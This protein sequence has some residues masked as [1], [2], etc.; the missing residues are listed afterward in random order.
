MSE[1]LERKKPGFDKEALRRKYREERDKR[2]RADGMDQYVEIDDQLSQNLE[3]PYIPRQERPSISDHVTFAFIGGGFS[4]LVTGARLVENGVMNVR[5]I[6]KGGDFGGTWYWNRYPGAICD[7]AA[8]VYLPLLE[9]TGHMPTKKYVFAPEILQQCKRIGTQYNLYDHALFHTQVT[10]L[11]WDENNSRWQITTDRGDAFTADF[12]GMGTGPLHKPK[13]PGIPGLKSFKGHSFHTIRW[14]YSYTGGDTDGAPLEKLADKRVA[15]IGTGATGIQC[16]PHVAR[17]AKATYVLQRTPSSVDVRNNHDIDEQWFKDMATPGW[18]VRWIENFTANQTG[19]P[20]KEDLVQDGWTDL[21]QRV[22]SSIAKLSPDQMSAENIVAA[23]EDADFEKMEEIRARVDTIVEDVATAENLKAWYQQ[24]CKRPCFHDEYLQAYNEPSCM[25]VDTDGQ[26]VE[27][28]TENGVV[29][30]GVEY[31]VD[32]IIY[33]TGFEFGTAYESR[34]GY[35]TIGKNGLKLSDY[36]AGGMRTLHGAH[37]H[38]FPNLFIVQA[39]QGANLVSNYPHNL[40]ECANTIGI[41][42]KHAIDHSFNQIEV[43]KEAEDSWLELL[44]QAPRRMVAGSTECTPGYYNN[45]GQGWGEGAAAAFAYPKGPVAYFEYL[46][47][48]RDSGE[49]EGVNFG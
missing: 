23:Y 46:K 28:I 29:V 39:A 35:D 20:A 3:D 27:R 19:H 34:S 48:W 44:L 12:V 40:T 14:D 25:L 22:H 33:A 6:E 49:F 11:T 47:A 9:E 21:F 32:C 4:G 24:L 43:T 15:V 45:E 13:L 18:Q 31:E 1:Q 17:A 16:I 37:V 38:G 5:L 26:G 30:A 41:M 42:V 36:W 2:I 7:T 8:M 10:G